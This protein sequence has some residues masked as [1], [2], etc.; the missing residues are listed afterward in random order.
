MSSE[1]RYWEWEKRREDGVWEGGIMWANFPEFWEN[2]YGI[3]MKPTG[4][5]ETDPFVHLPVYKEG[6]E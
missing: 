2:K 5:H 1:Q 4:T 3:F 6:E